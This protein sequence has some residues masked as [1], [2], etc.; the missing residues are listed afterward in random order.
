V[1]EDLVYQVQ[2][3]GV[4]D[5]VDVAAALAAGGD[6]A[7][8]AELA[9]VLACG[10]D[11]DS[12]PLHQVQPD[13]SGEHG[14]GARGGIELRLRRFRVGHR[15]VIVTAQAVSGQPGVPW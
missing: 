13:R 12:C 9:E 4:V 8:Q 6:D 1:F 15:A 5:G 14:E 7:G 10:G 11:A 3:V 2:D